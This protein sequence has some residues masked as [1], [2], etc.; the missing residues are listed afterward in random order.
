[1]KLE[2]RLEGKILDSIILEIIAFL[3]REIKELRIY[4]EP[5]NKNIIFKYLSR[6]KKRKE[7]DILNTRESK[8]N[9]ISL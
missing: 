4:K 2:E 1:M 5:G 6:K 9:I 7:L 3:E 8:A